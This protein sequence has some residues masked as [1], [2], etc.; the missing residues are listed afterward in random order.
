[1]GRRGSGEEGEWG[2]GEW[3]GG[4]MKR[5]ENGEEGGVGELERGCV[6][7]GF[8]CIVNTLCFWVLKALMHA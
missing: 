3:G 6:W 8:D 5:R 1:M 2:G 7:T 4:G